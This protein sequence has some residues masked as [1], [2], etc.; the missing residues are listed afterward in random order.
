MEEVAKVENNI[1]AALL[2][3]KILLNDG[4]PVQ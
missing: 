1:R 2:G 3:H 4:D